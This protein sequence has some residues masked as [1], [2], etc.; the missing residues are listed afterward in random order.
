MDLDFTPYFKEYEELLRTA[1]AVF[2]KVQAEYPDCVKCVPG[3]ADCCYAIFDLTLVEALYINHHF[4]QQ[5]DEPQKAAILKKAN[6]AD[7]QAFK[8]KRRAYKEREEGKDEN[9]ILTEMAEERIRC[10]LLN[11]ENR[12]EL[13]AQRPITCR[14]YG[15][16]TAFGGQGHTCGLSGFQAG[17]RYPTVNLDTI[18]QKLYLISY[19]IVR[20]I[21]SRHIQ[22]GDMLVPLSMALL[23]VYDPDYLGIPQ[24]KPETGQQP[25]DRS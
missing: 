9:T 1:D 4:Q 12:C 17:E 5:F 24:P 8:I 16:P 11:S 20:D 18:R 7:R 14:L 10:P 2:E 19:R 13:Y 21:R 23:T 6:E 22:M 25:A 15:V 3:C